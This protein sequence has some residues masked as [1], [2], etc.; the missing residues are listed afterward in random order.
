[1]GLP[2][3]WVLSHNLCRNEALQRGVGQRFLSH[4]HVCSMGLPLLPRITPLGS[5]HTGARQVGAGFLGC[6]APAWAL[7]GAT[8]PLLAGA[9]A[10]PSQR[11]HGFVSPR[12]CPTPGPW[13]RVG[14]FADTL[15][16]VCSGCH[17]NHR[18]GAHTPGVYF[19]TVLRTR[20]PRSR[21]W[22]V[23]LPARPLSL[24]CGW[25]SSPRACLGPDCLVSW[26]LRLIQSP[27]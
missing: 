16:V 20:S 5:Q 11:S 22:Q 26:G 15:M 24:V 23:C 27:L 7:P 8:R 21:C 4:S 12:A 6:A 17:D 18:L 25:R 14:L 2:G 1:M 9:C 19:L 10:R 3:T 13:S